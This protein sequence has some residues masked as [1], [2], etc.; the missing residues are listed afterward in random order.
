MASSDDG[1]RESPDGR[2]VLLPGGLALPVEPIFL[3]HELQSRGFVL[4]REGDDTTLSVQPWQKLTDEDRTRIRRWKCHLL[5]I[6]DYQAPE[7]V[8]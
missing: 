8:Q 7:L 2:Y 1:Y 3:M 6:V 4:R 5:S